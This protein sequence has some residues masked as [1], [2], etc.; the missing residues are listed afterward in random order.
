MAEAN[1]I[2]LG[3]GVFGEDGKSPFFDIPLTLGRVH[4]WIR[5]NED[6]EESVKEEL[7][8]LVNKY[9]ESALSSFVKN[10]NIH[11]VKARENATK[12]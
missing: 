7:V 12:R 2:N 4:N 11:L 1:R 3:V 6:I 10:F 5:R 8:L 9:P